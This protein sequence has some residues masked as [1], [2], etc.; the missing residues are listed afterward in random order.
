MEYRRNKIKFRGWGKETNEGKP[1]KDSMQTVM[2]V[3]AVAKLG[4]TVW[5]ERNL[6]CVHTVRGLTYGNQAS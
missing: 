4:E 1:E 3:K 6:A 2:R 5:T